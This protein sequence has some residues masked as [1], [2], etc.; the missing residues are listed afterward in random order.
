MQDTE[1]ETA[2]AV[3]VYDI[4]RS[5]MKKAVKEPF[6]A[7]VK[8][9]ISKSSYDSLIPSKEELNLSKNELSIRLEEGRTSPLV[10]QSDSNDRNASRRAGVS[11]KNTID[12]KLIKQTLENHIKARFAKEYN[13]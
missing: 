2:L 8:R 5:E 11:E 7:K 6:T 13:M 9:K 12:R 4:K 1:W 3:A 10:L